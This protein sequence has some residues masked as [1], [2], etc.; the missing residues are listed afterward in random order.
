MSAATNNITGDSLISKPTTDTYS[1]GWD[2]IF[3]KKE[4]III[5]DTPSSE[6]HGELKDDLNSSDN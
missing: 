5:S 2:R 4:K 1:A 6:D 3:G